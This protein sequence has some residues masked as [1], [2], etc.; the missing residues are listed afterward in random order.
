MSPEIYLG[1]AG[2]LLVLSVIV[3]FYAGYRLRARQEAEERQERAARQRAFQR[4]KRADELA[5]QLHGIP[6]ESLEERV[7]V[8][9]WPSIARQ[10]ETR[11]SVLPFVDPARR[12]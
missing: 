9:R 2:V 10:I 6:V 4:Q 8:K 7:S 11:E 1:D 5:A 12:R 3:S